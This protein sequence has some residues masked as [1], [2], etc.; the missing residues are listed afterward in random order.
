[1]KSDSLNV[2]IPK[3]STVAELIS[4]KGFSCLSEEN[5]KL[6]IT[7]VKES[8]SSD[9]GFMGKLVGTNPTNAA[10]NITLIICIV[11]VIIGFVTGG[12]QW[13]KI[14]PVIAGA[15]GYIFGKSSN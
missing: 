8:K 5:Q 14:M 3:E 13:D 15:I 1:M 9:G 2:N 12:T 11:L 6:A 4:Q 7:T 10:M